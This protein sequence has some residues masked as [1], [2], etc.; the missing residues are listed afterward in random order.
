M[1]CQPGLNHPVLHKRRA[2]QSVA[3][4]IQNVDRNRMTYICMICSGW[5]MIKCTSRH[6][7]QC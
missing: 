5:R 2:V 4:R 7:M 1:S 3:R 6:W